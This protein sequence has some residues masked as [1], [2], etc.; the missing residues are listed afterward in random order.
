MIDFQKS[1]IYKI[2]CKTSENEILFFTTRQ[3]PSSRINNI[4]VKYYDYLCGIPYEYEPIFDIFKENNYVIE[5]IEAY[6]CNHKHEIEQRILEINKNISTKNKN[7]MMMDEV[8][9]TRYEL[10]VEIE[11]LSGMLN[12]PKLKY[13]HAMSK[14]QLVELYN[15]LSKEHKNKTEFYS[16]HGGC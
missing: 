6:P 4:R 11:K 13:L 2:K 8:K 16:Q 14:R 12:Y 9:R 1:K 7:K 3:R 5:F 10:I 15:G